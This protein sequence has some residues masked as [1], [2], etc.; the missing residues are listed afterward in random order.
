MIS[1]E[2]IAMGD[3]QAFQIVPL[4]QASDMI[5]V[6]V[7]QGKIRFDLGRLPGTADG[8][9]LATM[10]SIFLTKEQARQFYGRVSGH[11]T[12]IQIVQFTKDRTRAR[13]KK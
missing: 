11:N 13:I 12:R 3:N 6:I 4:Y 8:F 2:T 5:I 10:E 7:I 1:Q 9:R